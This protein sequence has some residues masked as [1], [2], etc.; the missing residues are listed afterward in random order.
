M[1][2][3]KKAKSG[4]KQRKKRKETDQRE[5]WQLILQKMGMKYCSKWKDS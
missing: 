4:T 3:A 2:E 1:V 5:K